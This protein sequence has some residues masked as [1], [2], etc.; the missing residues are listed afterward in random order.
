M[1]GANVSKDDL[2]SYAKLDLWR[3]DLQLPYLRGLVIG[4]VGSDAHQM[5]AD[6]HPELCRLNNP[7]MGFYRL[8]SLEDV[9]DKKGKWVARN[10]SS[11]EP[12]G[13][14]IPW[15]FHMTMQLMFDESRRDLE[16]HG[17]LVGED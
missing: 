10:P 12:T 16:M 15:R 13:M 4:M 11:L 7:Q 8:V 9:K 6:A 5:L 17:R 14:F 3:L 2:M 1:N